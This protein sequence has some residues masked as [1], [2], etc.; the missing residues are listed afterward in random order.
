[1]KRILKLT[2][3]GTAFLILW[4]IVVWQFTPDFDR[5]ENSGNDKHATIIFA[6]DGSELGRLF[7]R[8]SETVF[9][10]DLPTHL[11]HALVATEDARYWNHNGTDTRAFARI[12]KGGKG[13][14]ST[15]T[16]QLAK[17]LFSSKDRGGIKLLWYK[18]LEM[19][20]AW[21]LERAYAKS[22]II[23]LYL[24]NVDYLYDSYGIA[25]AAR[26]YFGKKVADLTVNESAVLV[27]MLRNPAT[28]NPRRN[29]KACRDRR[30]T[31]LSQMVK[32]GYLDNE[33]AEKLSKEPI[34]LAF[35]RASAKS[36]LAPH[37]RQEVRKQAQDLLGNDVNLYQD[38]LRIY[39]AV[40]PKL[41]A[42][43]EQA[44]AEHMAWLQ[45]KFTD[46]WRVKKSNPF[47]YTGF[48]DMP[49]EQRQRILDDL[50]K[51]KDRDSL[52]QALMVLQTGVVCLDPK[53]GQVKAWVGGTDFA[54]NQ[55]DHVT[56]RRQV[57]STFKPIV[58]ATAIAKFE[59]SPCREII[60]EQYTIARGEGGFGLMQD[61][62][63]A[64]SDTFSNAS[65]NLFQALDQSKNSVSVKLMKEM[66]STQAVLETAWD[67]GINK[68]HIP[69]S[70]S[71]CLGAADLT[72]LEMAGAYTAF[73]HGGIA[74]RPILITKI[75]DNN[76][77]VLWQT[78]PSF[79]QVLSSKDAYTMLQLL[80][81]VTS[82]VKTKNSI[83]T[84]FGGK[85][86]TTN[87]YSDGWFMGIT[88]E[89]VIGCWVG[90]EQRFVRF[91][92][93]QLGQGAMMARPI[94]VKIIQ[95]AEK[96]GIL[97]KQAVFIRSKDG[98]DWDCEA[99]KIQQS[100]PEVVTPHKNNVDDDFGF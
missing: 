82:D 77:K 16:M 9:F 51:G 52:M 94:V 13:G 54:T 3:L 91:T 55:N 93:I 21:K 59:I 17:L 86:G 45:K 58:Y 100:Q 14:G 76:G 96:A 28:L 44:V 10:Q 57:G 78:E 46:H 6:E 20:T 60:D 40:N 27:G 75:E 26:T 61:W 37:F 15:I 31:V 98:V 83:S 23:A 41:Q 25:A 33:N 39:T 90:G 48:E 5:L 72:P 63:P 53:T 66:G 70:P 43:A 65:L 12:I 22:E 69:A 4:F 49:L 35:E 81:G 95:G 42:I 29:E 34:T 68:S 2:L 99:L 32:Y 11:V 47:D 62:S 24:S 97:N 88:P 38:G 56:A 1:M 87:N 64:N 30:N 84:A 89:L 80:Q 50:A 36:G 79:E 92:T 71:I 67:M 19:A 7:S 18:P 73:V 85:T 74:S 8:N